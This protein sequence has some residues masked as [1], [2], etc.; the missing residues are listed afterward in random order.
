MMQSIYSAKTGIKSQ[1]L[2]IDTIAN[3]I[4]NI[5]T[6]GFK[7]SR[8]TFKDAMY[9]AMAK[10][11]QTTGSNL[12]QG[13]GTLV[14]ATTQDFS[15]GI[16]VQTGEPLDMSIEGDGFFTLKDAAGNIEY[17]R[18]G[19][20]TVS[21]EKDGAYLVSGQGNYVL[22]NSGN[23]IQLPQTEDLNLSQEGALSIGT[24]APFATLGIATF[25][26]NAGLQNVGNGSFLSTAAS[27]PALKA[28]SAA[29]RQGSLEG[30][31][32]NLATELTRLIRAQRAFSLA[33]KAVTAADDMESLANN[34]RT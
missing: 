10:T 1:Q 5:D 16:P 6:N 8:V 28:D 21:Y 15:Q 13:N 20:F 9:V 3:N 4:A 25:E 17:T 34:I 23:R 22:D 24:A 26:N 14:S 12:Q 30:S 19:S 27:G 29:V 2:R 11:A 18:S 32:V 33:G 31:N 7:A